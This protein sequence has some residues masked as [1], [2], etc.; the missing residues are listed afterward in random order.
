MDFPT[1]VPSH[2]T[3]S[4]HISNGVI[5]KGGSNW[6][7][8]RQALETP[9]TPSTPPQLPTPQQHKNSSTAP[10]SVPLDTST[11]Q[12]YCTPVFLNGPYSPHDG[13]PS[14]APSLSLNFESNTTTL[15][16]RQKAQLLSEIPP[17]RG[18]IIAAHSSVNE[19][20]P[21]VISKQRATHIANFL[22]SQKIKV[23]F[24]ESFGTQRPL[25]NPQTVSENQRVDIWI[26]SVASK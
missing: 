6:D 22:K 7:P 19:T 15:S 18:V 24:T 9:I 4:N 14:K 5:V 23:F 17:N 1:F 2:I 12:C 10:S 25:P 11:A 16:T 20:N 13:L 21:S 26:Q 8:S 3:H